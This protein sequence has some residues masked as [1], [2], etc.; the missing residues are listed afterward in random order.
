MDPE[1]RHELDR[2]MDGL[3]AALDEIRLP[4]DED[5]EISAWHKVH[6]LVFELNRVLPG[7]DHRRSA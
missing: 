6:T 4:V 2:L 7:L 3:T 5:H 1:T